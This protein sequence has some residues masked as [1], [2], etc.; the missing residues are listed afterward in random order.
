ML[1]V[2]CWLNH[3]ILLNNFREKSNFELLLKLLLRASIRSIGLGSRTVLTSNLQAFIR[4]EFIVVSSFIEAIITTEINKWSKWKIQEAN[5]VCWPEFGP[6]LFH[7]KR[8][9]LTLGWPITWSQ[10]REFSRYYE[11]QSNDNY[12]E[13]PD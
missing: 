5:E 1:K 3:R 8:D 11:Y 6:A 12:P 13:H 9:A 2:K 7:Y 10:T 4:T